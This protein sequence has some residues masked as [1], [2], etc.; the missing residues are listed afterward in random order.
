MQPRIRKLE[1]IIG[2]LNRKDL[3]L[4]IGFEGFWKENKAKVGMCVNS[5]IRNCEKGRSVSTWTWEHGGSLL[6]VAND[7]EAMWEQERS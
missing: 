7:P 1:T 6:L 5:E 2:I 4:E 3:T